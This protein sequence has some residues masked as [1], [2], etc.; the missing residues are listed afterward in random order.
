MK[1]K[2]LALLLAAMMLLGL[3]ACGARETPEEAITAGM[4][5][6]QQL[7]DENLVKYF[8][9]EANFSAVATESDAGAVEIIRVL[10]PKLTYE[11]GEI[12][13]KDDTATAVVAV[14]NVDMS[15]AMS[16]YITDLMVAMFG[17]T[18]T[19]D[20]MT[21][22]YMAQMLIGAI[23]A[24]EDTV[25]T[26]VTFDMVYNSEA[27]CWNITCDDEAMA[28]AITGQMLDATNNLAD[29]LG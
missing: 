12:T 27:K 5:A 7:D 24:C 10:M 9:E 26:D 20:M 14:S 21:D 2:L 4:T 8:G 19:E 16:N 18:L 23:N 11:I 1:K 28:N 3:A 6:L 25:T 17:G 13:E 22:E 15:V 29:L